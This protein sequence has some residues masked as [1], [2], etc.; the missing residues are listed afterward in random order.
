MLL[1]FPRPHDFENYSS[2]D[3]ED[4]KENVLVSLKLKLC[5]YCILYN[6]YNDVYWLYIE[7]ILRCFLF[8][9]IS[10]IGTKMQLNWVLSLKQ[11]DS[12]Q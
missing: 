7:V 3:Y 2:D 6:Y 12:N 1:L 9:L 5:A 10:V 4:Y 8:N 11:F